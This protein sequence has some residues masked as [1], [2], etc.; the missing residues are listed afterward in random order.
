M[1]RWHPSWM[2]V[3][4]ALLWPEVSASARQVPDDIPASIGRPMVFED[5]PGTATVPPTPGLSPP[6]GA[7]WRP[8][9]LLERLGSPLSHAE[10]DDGR[11]NTDRPSFTPSNATVP[12]GRLQVESGYTFSH[13]LTRTTRNDEHVFPELAVRL[14]LND[15][16]E[17][18]T[19]WA[20]QTYS[21][22]TRLPGGTLLSQVDGPTNY[23]A[24]F[25]WKLSDQDTWIPE[26]ALITDL[27]IPTSGS[28]PNTSDGVEPVLALL[29]GWDL[30]ERFTL[31]GS[32]GLSTDFDRGDDVAP[33]GDSFERFSQS[34]VGFLS[35]REDV[36][37]FYEWFVLSRT[38]STAK[39]PQHSMDGGIIYQPTPNIQLD[40]RAGFGLG[41][42]PTDFFTGAGLSFRY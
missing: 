22:T 8:E 11:I 39:L 10:D 25:K 12:A 3:G 6:P 30:T 33:L 13:D 17:L 24:G 41:D 20:G 19:F 37:L 2:L 40:L 1:L 26:A 32:T 29:Y 36:T 21:R 4:W 35:A 28:S 42:H 34:F 23:L 14:G 5:R 18:R 38:N 15:W 9:R 7:L 31:A 27:A 16:L